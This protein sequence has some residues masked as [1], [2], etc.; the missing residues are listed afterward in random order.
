MADTAATTPTKQA[1]TEEEAV[2][3]D[4]AGGDKVRMRRRA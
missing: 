1:P 4:E 2:A 3:A